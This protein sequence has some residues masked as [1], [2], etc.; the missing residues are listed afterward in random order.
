MQRE[1]SSSRL[2]EKDRY[3]RE[4]SVWPV[5]AEFNTDEW[6]GNFLP[7]EMRVAERLLTNFTYFNERM[8]DALLRAAIQNYFGQEEQSSSKNG[9]KLEDYVNETA[10]VTCEAETPRPT[11][12]GHLFARK[13]RDK[14]LIPEA[15]IMRP[16]DALEKRANFERFIFIDD[17]SGSGNQFVSTWTRQHEIRGKQYSFQDFSQSGSQHFAYCCC[18]ATW[19]AIRKIKNDAASVTLSSAHQL[20]ERH[21]AV[22]A[23]SSIWKNLEAQ[24]A[25]QIIKAASSRAGYSAE[26]GG[27]NDWRGFHALGLTLSFSHGIPDASLPLFY[28]HRGN[29]K[30]LIVRT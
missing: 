1:L 11:D 9:K 13:L 4:F 24:P 17:F 14:I 18:I 25:K 27:Q 3:F 5:L 30:P 6:L 2:A 15:N 10:F 8:T 16:Q 23:K 26:N 22:D 12:S 29:W 21:S 19:K 20:L 28:S 7:E